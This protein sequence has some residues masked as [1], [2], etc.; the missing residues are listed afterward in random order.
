MYDI[1][2]VFGQAKPTT[3]LLTVTKH[4]QL[5]P[6]PPPPPTTEAYKS[7][8]ASTW[9][10]R[11]DSTKPQPNHTTHEIHSTNLIHWHSSWQARDV[12][13]RTRSPYDNNFL[14]NIIY[15]FLSVYLDKFLYAATWFVVWLVRDTSVRARSRC[16]DSTG[17]Y[18][19]NIPMVLI[20]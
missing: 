6:P 2:L 18:L 1:D 8:T 4:L 10:Q 7:Q 3:T 15:Y 11:G 12:F 5:P 20:L 9:S 16:V 17:F 14:L 13:A 19:G